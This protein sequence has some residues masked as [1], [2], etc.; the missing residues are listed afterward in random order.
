MNACLLPLAACDGGSIT[1]VEAVANADGTLAPFQR[2]LVE[3]GGSQCGFCTPGIVMS[4][5]AA[6]RN[7]AARGVEMSKERVREAVD[8]NLCRCTGYRPILQAFDKL[9]EKRGGGVG[10][11]GAVCG[12]GEKCCKVTSAA[13]GH[14]SEVGVNANG[15]MEN[16]DGDVRRAADPDAVLAWEYVFPP[17]LVAYRA[18]ELHLAEDRWHTPSTLTQLC[19]LRVRYP[20]AHIVVGNTEL[21]IDVRFKDIRVS[22]YINAAHVPELCAIEEQDD[23]LRIGSS[24]T[25]TQLDEHVSECF[26]TRSAEG[27]QVFQLG[28][29]RAVQQQLR[30]FAGTQI[31]NVAAVGGNIVT[32][33]PISDVNPV[34][35]AAGADF[36]LMDCET[37]ATRTVSARNFF[38]SYRKVDLAP[39]EV[40]LH[41]FVPWNETPLDYTH[42]FK[43]S[44]RREDDIAIVSAGV[45]I[46]LACDDSGDDTRYVIDHCSVSLGGVAPKTVVAESVEYVLLG[47]PFSQDT[48]QQGMDA[49]A[50]AVQLPDDVPGGMPEFRKCLAVAFLFK[51]FARCAKAVDDFNISSGTYKEPMTMTSMGIKL[52]SD[53]L[54]RDKGHVINSAI[55]IVPDRPPEAD[56]QHTGKSIPHM[57]AKLQVTGEAKYLD[58]IPRYDR[59]LQG[60]LVLSSEP[61]AEILSVDYA[62]AEQMAGVCRIVRARDVRGENKIGQMLDELCFA[63]KEVTVVGQ[64]IALVLADTN[65]QAKRA[66]KA[67]KV[68]YKRLPALVTIEDAIEAD[69]YAPG[70]PPRTIR[71]GDADAVIEEYRKEGRV[72]EGCVRIG[73]QEHWYLEPNG[74]IAVPGENGEMIVLSSTQ[75]PSMTQSNA[76]RVLGAPMN[77]VTCKVKRL[78]G[79]FGGKETRCFFISNATAVAAQATGRPV[80]LILDRDTDMM[81]T[82]TR[83]AFLAK[84][85]VAFENDGRIKALKLDI[86]LNMGNSV[87]L[88]IA[89]LDRCLYHATNS[90]DIEHASFVGRACFTHSPSATAFRGFGGPQGMMIV[91]DVLE[92]VACETK[93]PSVQVRDANL[94]G[95]HGNTGVTPYGMSF[96]AVPLVKCWDEVLLQSNYETRRTSID[97]FN[98]THE[99]RKRGLAGIPTMFGISFSFRTLNQASALIHIFHDDGSVLISHG[100]VEMGQ[101]LHTKMCQIAATTLG[102]DLDLVYISDTDTDKVANA[103][104]TA[105]SA[106]SDMYGMAVQQACETLGE[107]LSSFR[108]GVSWK[109]A[110]HAAWF[111]RVSLSATGFFS[112]PD[113][114]AVDLSTSGGAARGR[115][116][117]YF[118]N[119]AAVSEVEVDI[120][121][122]EVDLVRTDIVMD[123]GRPINA[124]IDIGQIEGGFM[125]GLG[126]CTMEEVVR[127][128]KRGHAW[129]SEGRMHTLGPG[130]YKI[131]AFGD[132]PRQ[133]H[134]TVLDERNDKA[135]VGGSK[136]V[137]EPPLFLAASVYFAVKDAVGEGEWVQM[138][139]PASVE[140]V[141]MAARDEVKRRVLGGKADIRPKLSL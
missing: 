25:W 121:T 40:L 138:D 141:R 135:T 16:G 137:G 114:D 105:A 67:V 50:S 134:V 1:T 123:I 62:E 64:V 76:A 83:H 91:E 19:E 79:G 43:V 47:K 12:L 41:V 70:V 75:S 46:R 30:L 38:L 82:G 133:F 57:A 28:S 53:L 68:N 18:R 69:S 36:V 116:F 59:E 95:K 103:S 115:P 124:G 55:Q 6:L 107:R 5:F 109:E 33:S 8:G 98:A 131:P 122:G 10:A 100:G 81:I 126:W 85:E 61:H 29:L 37:G 71:K 108:S 102:I 73:A 17:E 78:G 80:R 92:R 94:Y 14:V 58:D 66:A 15:V 89:V 132:I 106:S 4:F 9:I 52:D 60:A 88:S 74:T 39:T 129:L 22:Q 63:E 117:Y 86:Y 140:R 118:T 119:G 65:Q 93:I 113:L 87:D 111:D 32:A 90:Y 44:R 54:A 23:G 77:K 110:V 104:P 127:G 84:Y 3:G 24:V 20:E 120:L 13:N 96:D 2:A 11:N 72:A 7:A 49:M 128:S 136:A 45:R 34:W 130:T 21:G 139:V 56:P 112:T 51:A 35:M 42:A 31:R 26:S 97:E 48:L 101:G 27:G 125:Q 99:Y